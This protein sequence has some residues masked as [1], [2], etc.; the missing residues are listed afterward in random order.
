VAIL[1]T[2]GAARVLL[3]SDVEAREEK[4]MASGSCTRP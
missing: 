3:A 2:Y 4:V 1:L